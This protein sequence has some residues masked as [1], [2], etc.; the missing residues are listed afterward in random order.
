L[1]AGRRVT[2]K[3]WVLFDSARSV[4]ITEQLRHHARETLAMLE[5]IE[6]DRFAEVFLR[7][8]SL[9]VQVFDECLR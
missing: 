3:W 1:A 6:T 8:E 4:L 7:S 9:P 5:D 2:S